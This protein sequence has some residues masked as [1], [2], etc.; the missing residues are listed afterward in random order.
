[1]VE[2]T[3]TRVGVIA[4]QKK[5]MNQLKISNQTSSFFKFTS[6]KP[7]YVVIGLL[8]SIIIYLVFFTEKVNCFVCLMYPEFILRTFNHPVHRTYKNINF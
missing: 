6:G 2:I 5:Q 8:P 1:M 3:G 7:S 4:F